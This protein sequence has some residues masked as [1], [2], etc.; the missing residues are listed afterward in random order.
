NGLLK[1]LPKTLFV[2]LEQSAKP[3]PSDPLLTQASLDR[4]FSGQQRQSKLFYTYQNLVI[5]MLSG[6]RTGKLGVEQITAPSGR[7]FPATNRERTLIDITVRPAYAGGIK[8]VLAC[9]QAARQRVDTKQL[10]NMLDQI[11]YLYPYAQAIGFLGQ[12]AEFSDAQLR[13]L[14]ERV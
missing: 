2:N 7:A 6:K 5:T 4:A 13:I 9:Y 11:D 1:P 8:A 14:S 3:P 10:V 12:R